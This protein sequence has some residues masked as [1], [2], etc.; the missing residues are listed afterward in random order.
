MIVIDTSALFAIIANEPER[1]TYL[2]RIARQDRALL[3]AV[4]LYET[5][6]VVGARLGAAGLAAL[7]EL[8]EAAEIEVVPFDALQARSSHAAY[9]TYGKGRY[10]SAS[11]NLC[12]CVAYALAKGL[13]APLLFK[14]LD[15]AATDVLSAENS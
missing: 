15:F 2:A 11:L 7:S 13:D 4:S 8:L 10:P 1:D 14:G 9:Q 6:L 3:S 5:M 12:D